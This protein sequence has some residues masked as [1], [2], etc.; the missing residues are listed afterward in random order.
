MVFIHDHGK[1]EGPKTEKMTV[2]VNITINN[3][4][5]EPRVLQV[6]ENHYVWLKK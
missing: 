5:E 2:F 1:E 6:T 3:E 4:G